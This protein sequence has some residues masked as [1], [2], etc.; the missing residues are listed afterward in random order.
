MR[1]NLQ[2]RMLGRETQSSYRQSPRVGS[3]Y[4][5]KEWIRNLDVVNELDG[6][7]GC[8]NALRY[9]GQYMSSTITDMLPA[10]PSLVDFLLPAQ[11]TSI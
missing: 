6:H 7:S 3:I 10:G 11:T 1:D 4:G 8:V 5:D 9:V 2:F